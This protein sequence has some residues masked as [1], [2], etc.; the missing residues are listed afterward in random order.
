MFTV[1]L[2]DKKG[3]LLECRD[4]NRKISAEDI[5]DI[6]D[7]YGIENCSISDR[8]EREISLNEI[9]RKSIIFL[10]EVLR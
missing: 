9:T 3:N 1:V 10:K 7:I 4:Y 8:C 2:L 6:K 5:A